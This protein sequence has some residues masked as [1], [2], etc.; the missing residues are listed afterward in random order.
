MSDAKAEECSRAW[1]ER[2]VEGERAI[3]DVRA[4][5]RAA[6]DPTL[7]PMTVSKLATAWTSGDLLTKHGRV[8]GLRKPRGDRGK[9][10]ASLLNRAISTRPRGPEGP[11][12]GDLPVPDVTEQ[13]IET[14]LRL[15]PTNGASAAANTLKNYYG[16]LHRLFELA[17]RPCRL[18]PRGSNPVDRAL[19]PSQD[20]GK[21]FS[22]LLPEELLAVLRLDVPVHDK[23]LSITMS[24][25]EI[26]GWKMLIVLGC[27]LGL[28]KANLVGLRWRDVDIEGGT[29]VA[30]RTKT[31]LPISADVHFAPVLTLLA[32]WKKHRP[33]SSEDEP[34]VPVSYRRL[35]RA[36]QV[37]HA[38]LRAA[39]VTREILF[40]DDPHVEP[41]R[42]HDLRS[43]FVTWA[44]RAGLP[45]HFITSRTGHLTK[46]M[47]DR[48]TRLATSVAA[49]RFQPFP[50][51]SKA[52]PELN[53][54]D[55]SPDTSGPNGV[56]K[57]GSDDENLDPEALARLAPAPVFKTDH[58]DPR[59]TFTA[60]FVG[61]TQNVDADSAR[62][63][64]RRVVEV[65]T[66]PATESAV[67]GLTGL[68]RSVATERDVWDRWDRVATELEEP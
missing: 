62:L 24:V 28:R 30:L 66:D 67:E 39:G 20:D 38:M 14:V 35:H 60:P 26:T 55:T 15:A 37:L 9:D 46:D 45:E 52:I 41:L 63:S 65:A 42:F 51:V 6:K 31:G 1:Y 2:R 12:F 56:D 17:E 22:F 54:P 13:D 43:T 29:F 57:S 68:A 11:A 58:K 5:K 3:L 21:I 50:D 49:S 33:P 44:K 53:R 47:V 7:A 40:L 25:E 27:Y 18:R 59:R 4:K 36:R 34:I 16:A 23:E 61:S 64:A 48:Y 10:T 32:A 19:R 8:N